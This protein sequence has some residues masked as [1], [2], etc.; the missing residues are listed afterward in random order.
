MTSYSYEAR[1]L[2]QASLSVDVDCCCHGG[3]A[4]PGKRYCFMFLRGP[5]IWCVLPVVARSQRPVFACRSP[6]FSREAAL[7]NERVQGNR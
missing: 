6:A 5:L 1:R 2:G 3:G 7:R 4:W